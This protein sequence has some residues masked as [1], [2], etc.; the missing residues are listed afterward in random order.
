MHHHE[1]I[2]HTV[3]PSAPPVFVPSCMT[4]PRHAASRP[5]DCCAVPV[6]RPLKSVLRSALCLLALTTTVGAADRD[7]LTYAAVREEIEELQPFPEEYEAYLEASEALA[8]DGL[9]REAHELLVELFAGAIAEQDSLV[10]AGLSAQ[11]AGNEHI[12]LDSGLSRRPGE[13]AVESRE[14]TFTWRL[15]MSGSYDKFDDVYLTSTDEDTLDLLLDSLDEIDQQPYNGYGR[16]SLEWEPARGPLEHITPS[17]YTSNTRIRGGVDLEGGFA[18][19]GV[20]FEAGFEAEKRLGEEY[21]DSS[22]AVAGEGR[23]RL[24][25]R[26]LTGRF[27]AFLPVELETEQYRTQRSHYTSYRELS[28]VPSLVLESVDFSRRI[29]L[30]YRHMVRRHH[31]AGKE[32]DETERGPRLLAELYGSIVSASLESSMEW[33][34]FPHRTD[35]ARRRELRMLFRGTVRPRQWL[36]PGLDAEWFVGREWYDNQTIF[37]AETDTLA[38]P[39]ADTQYIETFREIA[40]AYA[41]DGRGIDVRPSL[42]FNLPTGLSVTPSF[43][44][45]LRDYPGKTSH[46]S[47]PLYDTL[48]ISESYRAF[49]PGMSV[50]IDRTKWY[51]SVGVSRRR[52]DSVSEYYLEDFTALRP[53][54]ELTW[55]LMPGM[56]LDLYGS[57][58]HRTYDSGEV[59]GN[60]SASVSMRL[61]F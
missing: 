41:L 27:Y 38:I 23:L 48:Y 29:E 12:A 5:P 31:E 21:G 60:T 24:S 11:R 19:N 22:D 10:V 49:E 46:D 28:L 47:L 55:F 50:S 34:R 9:Y 6:F 25:S 14:N 1:L 37:A 51:A 44:F 30:G 53:A 57:Y 18:E 59:E 7:S 56:S 54:A 35:P 61:R 32:D 45:E 42:R 58:E 13:T 36:E 40:G 2:A 39:G 3:Q 16:V 33:E 20:M 15:G 8:D 43:N 52:E 17:V 26:P 4:T